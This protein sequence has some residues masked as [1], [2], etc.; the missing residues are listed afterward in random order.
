MERNAPLD[1]W[2]NPLDEIRRA[3]EEKGYD[4]NTG[5]FIQAFDHPQID[6]A[7]LLLLLVG[8]VAYDD[9]RMIWTTN[10]DRE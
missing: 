4:R 3:I 5:I 1:A 8:F 6:A 7:L 2:L 10:S 9:E